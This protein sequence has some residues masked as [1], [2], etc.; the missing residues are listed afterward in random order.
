VSA[1]VAEP[2][3]EAELWISFA[4]ML[5][6]YFVA[7]SLDVAAD[8]RVHATEDA[9]TLTLGEARM[10]I[11]WNRA[12]GTGT[13]RMEGAAAQQGAF[14]LLEDGRVALDGTAMDLDHAA[15]DL[16]ARVTAAGKK[17]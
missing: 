2:M 4:S 15:I 12:E 13:W 1:A 7:A 17:A 3:I 5:R 9:V 16:V 10:A 6:S 11:A 8:A 14:T